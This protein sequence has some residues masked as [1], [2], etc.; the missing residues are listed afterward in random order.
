MIS[1]NN[2]RSGAI[3]CVVVSVIAFAP[4]V[5]GIALANSPV[6]FD[7]GPVTGNALWCDQGP[8]G[9]GGSGNWT[10]YDNFNLPG[11]R[12][13]TEFDYTDI[14]TT[15]ANYVT[16]NWSLWNADPFTAGAPA[17]SG[18]S[19]ATI[20]PAGIGQLFTVSGLSQVLPAGV[21]WL[22]INNTMRNG[23][24][25]SVASATGVLAGA[26]Q[27]DGLTFFYDGRPERAFR[28]YGTN[29]PEPT[30]SIL[31]L[32]GMF[33]GGACRRRPASL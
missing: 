9:C 12:I 19:V 23:D 31:V 29:V 8:S 5:S 14:L 33:V 16:T 24:E 10:Y 13:I 15:P 4:N 18:S 22:G 27:S 30:G 25:V 21:Y 11:P 2:L 17:A 26:K 6:I 32:T 20:A 1:Y 3:R 28:I 7:N